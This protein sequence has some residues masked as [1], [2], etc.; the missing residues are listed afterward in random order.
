MLSQRERVYPQQVW[1]YTYRYHEGERY[2]YSF[3]TSLMTS[4][5][6]DVHRLDII[7]RNMNDCIIEKKYLMETKDLP[8]TRAREIDPSGMLSFKLWLFT[9]EIA[10]SYNMLRSFII[11]SEFSRGNS[12]MIS[13]SDIS[14]L[15]PVRSTITIK[16]F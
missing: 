1:R 12:F 14:K 4:R 7:T 15:L 9:K 16:F 11:L 10:E 13:R 8:S 6:R 3:I 5:I 2:A